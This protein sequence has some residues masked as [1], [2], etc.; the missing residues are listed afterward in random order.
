MIADSPWNPPR[1][2]RMST[3]TA[4][5]PSRA[6]ISARSRR[7]RPTHRPRPKPTNPSSARSRIERDR[8]ADA[9]RPSHR[10]P[11]RRR[12]RPH[13]EPREHRDGEDVD[14]RRAG[15][16]G[17]GHRGENAAD[18]GDRHGEAFVDPI[19]AHE[20]RRLGHVRINS[21][22]AAGRGKGPEDMPAAR[23]SVGQSVRVVD[24]QHSERRAGQD[25]D[26]AAERAVLE[27]SRDQARGVR[28]ARHSNGPRSARARSGP[29]C[30]E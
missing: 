11:R 30:I 2:A 23:P 18:H 20:A 10:P 13:G 29:G 24:V 9:A 26:V 3:L 21:G 19:P 16:P 12:R 8:S 4:T 15:G 5:A 25:H 1:S 6:R 28:A 27:S 7:R 17:A 14:R 22:L